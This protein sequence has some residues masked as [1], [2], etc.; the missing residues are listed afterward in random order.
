MCNI[1]ISDEPIYDGTYEVTLSGT[2]TITY[3]YYSGKN[4]A[5]AD[6]QILD[7]DGVV[8]NSGSLYFEQGYTGDTIAYSKRLW[9][10]PGYYTLIITNAY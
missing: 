10:D 8:V 1:A 9:L 4:Y 3:S 2:F 6:Y 7:S 5:S